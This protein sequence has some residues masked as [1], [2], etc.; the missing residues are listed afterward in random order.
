MVDAGLLDPHVDP[1]GDPQVSRAL[2]AAA[3]GAGLT[4][5][6][7]DA[8]RSEAV[9]LSA[10]SQDDLVRTHRS[11]LAWCLRLERRL[12][13]A[14]Q[15]F[16]DAGGIDFLVVKGPA[17]AHL[18]EHDPSSRTFSDVD[19]LVGS[20]HLE[21]SLK[22][23]EARG[24][25]RP[26][27]ERRPRFDRRFAKSVTVTFPDG[28]EFDVHR[29][30]CD[31]V[32]GFRIP[33]DRLFEDPDR[34]RLAGHDLAALAPVHRVLHAAYHAVLG[35]PRPRLMSLRDAL[36]YLVRSDLQVADV[37]AEAR[38]WRGEAVLAA[39]VEEVRC[40]FGWLPEPWRAWSEQVEVPGRETRIIAQQKREGS[41]FGPAKVSALME[42]PWPD[43]ASYAL[44]VA[45]PSRAHLRSRDLDL[46]TL[47]RGAGR[48]S[49]AKS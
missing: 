34:F 30:L 16:E 2:V 14:A 28:M 29:S 41:S 23:L 7:L 38:A 13:L 22:E 36:G 11:K 42:L 48:T 18:D 19:L 1:A 5:A 35:S 26:Y 17:I 40:S 10:A 15:W 33:L 4:G 44:G 24:A 8:V 3:A 9:E 27:V 47:L 45:V 20:A 43:R 31:G 39:A 12:V 32:H 21:R 46:F 6:L 37:V 49:R 25:V